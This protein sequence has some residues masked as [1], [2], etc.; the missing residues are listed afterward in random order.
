MN[1]GRHDPSNQTRQ[2]PGEKRRPWLAFALSALTL[3]AAFAGAAFVR[4]M[5]PSEGAGHF[6]SRAAVA[7]PTPT[8]PSIQH[9]ITVVMENANLSTTLSLGPFER[10]LAGKYAFASQYYA[11]CHPSTS[12]YLSMTSGNSWQCG[13]NGGSDAYN[14]YSTLNVADLLE[15]TGHSWRAY[16][17]S[18]PTPCN[19]TDKGAYVVHHNPF[20]YY[21]DIVGNASRCNTHVLPLSAFAPAVAAGTV[22]NYAFISPNITDD[23]TKNV[24][25]G[26][27]WLK[28][29]LSPLLN[30]SF[31]ASSVVFIAYDEA[32]NDRNGFNGTI[33]GHTY[34]VAVSPLVKL[35]STYSAD[36]THYNLLSTVE[37]LLGLGST[38]HNDSAVFGPMTGLFNLSSPPGGP[39]TFS[40]SG[41]VV[42]A[43]TGAGIPAATVTIPNHSTTITNVSGGYVF[44][45]TNGT[46]TV[47]VAAPGYVAKTSVVP[48]RGLAAKL[49]FVLSPGTQVPAFPAWAWVS[50]VV[51]AGAVVVGAL[52]FAVRGPDRSAPTPATKG[53]P[54]TAE[55]RAKPPTR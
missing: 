27:N 9:V 6:L 19:T 54:P 35:N 15:S 42:A 13:P 10:Y 3:V 8:P 32:T 14:V 31:F 22:P 23:G 41:R 51:V 25:F 4:P 33:G 50:A 28:G 2:S 37:W 21:S 55:P 12:N 49:D 17:E 11:V 45:L 1:V 30:D 18:M 20:V 5:N 53:K 46:Y 39:S 38:G 48:I 43:G 26:D 7:L 16:M 24:T 36:A 40:L 47:K 29:W 44:S 34:F 52:Y